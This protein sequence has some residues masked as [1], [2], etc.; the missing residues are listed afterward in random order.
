M[1][2]EMAKGQAGVGDEEC[3]LGVWRGER[4]GKAGETKQRRRQEAGSSTDSLGNRAGCGNK[5]SCVLQPSMLKSHWLQREY[6]CSVL[7][8]EKKH[9]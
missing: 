6:S 5:G 9:G 2:S 1:S 3:V 4:G 8:Q 7:N